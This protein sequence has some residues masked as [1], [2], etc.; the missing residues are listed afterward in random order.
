MTDITGITQA[1]KMAMEAKD[2]LIAELEQRLAAATERA[3]RAQADN[4]AYQERLKGILG[5]MC[6]FPD[7]E[8]SVAEECDISGTCMAIHVLLAADANERAEKAE[9]GAAKLRVELEGQRDW[10]RPMLAEDIPDSLRRRYDA[11]CKVLEATG[12][13]AEFLADAR[14]VTAALEKTQHIGE[15]RYLGEGVCPV[16]EY[17]ESH[18]HEPC[19]SIGEALARAKARGWDKPEPRA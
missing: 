3:E 16:C 11:I 6:P 12:V 2:A 7:P 4:A 19:C 1:V 10:L 9:A 17:V 18:G 13:G 15:R 14:A 5:E 8:C